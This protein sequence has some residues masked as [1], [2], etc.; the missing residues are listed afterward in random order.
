MCSDIVKGVVKKEVVVKMLARLEHIRSN[1]LDFL[2][3]IKFEI[4]DHFQK[5][6]TSNLVEFGHIR[7]TFGL[8]MYKTSKIVEKEVLS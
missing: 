5:N 8:T 4:L 7:P 1:S 6:S 2:I 3:S